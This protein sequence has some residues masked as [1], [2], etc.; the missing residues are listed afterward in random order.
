MNQPYDH[1]DTPDRS[2]PGLF[3]ITGWRNS[4][5]FNGTH[6]ALISPLSLKTVL[7][8]LSL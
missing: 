3:S 4:G 1:T 8:Y 5:R 2:S 6:A 7:L